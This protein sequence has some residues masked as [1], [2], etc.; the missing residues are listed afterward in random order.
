MLTHWT[1]DRKRGERLPL[2]F[3]VKAHTQDTARAVGLLDRGILK[4]GYKADLNVIDYQGLSL[5]RPE[6]GFDLP[7]GGR[8]LVQRAKGYKAT[9]VS[10]E[11]IA[12]DDEGTGAVPGKLLR[13]AQPAPA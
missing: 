11:I 13:G 9:I 8:R 6:V 5:F 3:V 10:G 2:S 4:P 7:A 1:R 12:R